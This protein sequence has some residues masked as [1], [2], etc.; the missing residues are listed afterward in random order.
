MLRLKN[1]EKNDSIVGC[2][3]YIEDCKEHTRFAVNIETGQ[4]VEA[5]APD[6]YTYCDNYFSHARRKII[7]L[8]KENLLPKECTVMWY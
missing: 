5:S 4:I 8:V 6:G 3:L 7:E 2:D 1:L